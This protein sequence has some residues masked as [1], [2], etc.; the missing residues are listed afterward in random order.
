[1]SGGEYIGLGTSMVLSMRSDGKGAAARGREC[2]REVGRRGVTSK[3][4]QRAVLYSEGIPRERGRE[5]G[6]RLEQGRDERDGDKQDMSSPHHTGG[7]GTR[8]SK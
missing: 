7:G 3:V 6:V 2:D 8:S 5:G 4:S 1:M